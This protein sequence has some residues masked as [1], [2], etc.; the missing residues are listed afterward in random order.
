MY[1]TGERMYVLDRRKGKRWK[2]RD[3]GKGM[4]GKDKEKRER[5]LIGNPGNDMSYFPLNLAGWWGVS[6]TG[7]GGMSWILKLFSLDGRPSIRAICCIRASG[8]LDPSG[9]YAVSEHPGIWIHPGACRLR[10]GV[11]SGLSRASGGL[12]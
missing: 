2:E 7:L 10:G 8:D 9:R 11:A 5:R 3:W 1:R 12:A 6:A 4:A